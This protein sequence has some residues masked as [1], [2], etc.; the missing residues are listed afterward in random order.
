MILQVPS[1]PIQPLHKRP[2]W[3]QKNLPN[4]TSSA[5]EW[6]QR[7]PQANP[8]RNPLL[9]TTPPKKTRFHPPKR[10]KTFEK[11]HP[12]QQ[13]EHKGVNK[14]SLQSRKWRRVLTLFFRAS[15]VTLILSSLMD[16]NFLCASLID[17]ATHVTKG[18]CK[19][20][21]ITPATIAQPTTQWRKT[22]VM[23]IWYGP[24]HKVCIYVMASCKR[25][26]STAIKFTISPEVRCS[27]SSLPP[28][29]TAF[30]NTTTLR[31]GRQVS[32]RGSWKSLKW[33]Y[34]EVTP[35]SLPIKLKTS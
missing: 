4:R 35:W 21:T 10:K 9:A 5:S 12:S 19:I 11:N 18:I 30:W 32:G 14:N 3:T 25:C 28:N 16:I 24:L 17:R 20:I 8:F 2:A 34:F 31:I 22:K 13:E 23:M 15:L 29:T 26:E 27:P 7:I 33:L 6:I 1:I